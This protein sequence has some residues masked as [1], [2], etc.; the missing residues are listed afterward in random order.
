M[1]CG[2]VSTC[3]SVQ[4]I[5]LGMLDLWGF[6]WD[7]TMDHWNMLRSMPWSVVMMFLMGWILVVFVSWSVA[8]GMSGSV[9][10]F[11]VL[12]FWGLNWDTIV[13]H[14]DVD[15]A[16]PFLNWSFLVVIPMATVN[17]RATFV[18]TGLDGSMGSIVG[19]FGSGN[20]RGLSWDVVPVGRVDRTF[21]QSSLGF[22]MS[23][24]VSSLGSL[25][26]WSL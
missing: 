6:N 5:G 13:N 15:G 19:M 2:S 8:L 17:C 22:S 18:A 12:H 14:R 10:G 25:N 24:K 21:V 7:S 11:G 26:F 9:E 4:V 23:S 20:F 1:R 3:Q 16:V